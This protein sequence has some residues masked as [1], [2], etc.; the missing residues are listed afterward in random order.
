MTLGS[1][2]REAAQEMIYEFA[3]E[4]GLCTY[5]HK[6]G[7]SYDASTGVHTP[8]Y[9]DEQY[10]IVFD[11]IDSGLYSSGASY[12]ADYI[13]SHMLAMI[14]GADLELDVSDEDLI[15]SEGKTFKVTYWET[16]MYEALYSIHV[17]RLPEDE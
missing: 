14:A 2:F 15:V 5:R 8:V 6:T 13:N 9:Q 10:Y 3:F 17:P 11:E 7:E 4:N 12:D 16:D 1:E